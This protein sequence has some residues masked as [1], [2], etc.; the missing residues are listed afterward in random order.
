M[1]DMSIKNNIFSDNMAS[2]HGGGMVVFEPSVD[3]DGTEHGYPSVTNNVFAFNEVTDTGFGADVCIWLSSEPD[4][5][6]NIIAG[7]GEGAAPAVYMSTTLGDWS[8]NA[9][10]TSAVAYGGATTDM[11]GTSGNVEGD[12]RFEDASDN[13]D[14]SDDDFRLRSTS[15]YIDHGD[16][17]IND[18]DGT[19]SD[20]GAY[21]G[22]DGTW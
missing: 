15:P 2:T 19:R 22:P 13:G 14:W 17:Y 16:P 21:G 20:I 12:P 5:V 8:Y 4:F 9:V 3:E 11:T 18:V 6:N 10:S 7:T 1:S